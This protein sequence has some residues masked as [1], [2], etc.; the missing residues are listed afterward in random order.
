MVKRKK[1]SRRVTAR[2]KTTRKA[3]NVGSLVQLELKDRVKAE[4]WAVIYLSL[5]LL[6]FLSITGRLGIVGEFVIN[7]LNPIFG[8][9]IY[10]LPAVLFGIAF[11]LFFIE[12]VRLN[13]TK[14]FGIALLFASVLGF[15]HLAVPMEE[16][17][18]YAKS[19]T[20]GGYIGFVVSFLLQSVLGKTGAYIVLVS[21]FIIAFLV[22]F[23]VSIS[24]VW[25]ALR[26]ELP[27]KIEK[28]PKAPRKKTGIM[29]QDTEGEMDINIIAPDSLDELK[30][31][32]EAEALMKQ[33]MNEDTNIIFESDGDELIKEYEKTLDINE[34][35]NKKFATSSDII[36]DEEKPY[37]PIEWE[38]P[39]VDLLEENTE[40][41]V[42]DN[43]VIKRNA[44]NI[45]NKL[46][47]FNIDV[48]MKDVHVGPTVVQYSLKPHEGVKLSKIT[49]LKQDL[50]LALAAKAI[51][52]EAPIPGQSLVG[53]EVPNETRSTV[54][55]RDLIESKEY[56]KTTSKLK[57]AI[58]RDVCGRSVIADLAK[59][60]HLLIAG[61]TGSGKS[62]GMNSFL[63]SLLYNN[64]PEELKMI[65][66]D[67]KRV[68][69]NNYN[70]IPHLLTPVITDPE[71]AATSLRWAVAEMNSRYQTLA[72]AG[73]RHIGDYNADDN[74]IVKMPKIII[75]ID[76]L[77]DLMMASG[78]EVEASICRIAQMA[79][80]IG[81]H[82]IIATQRPS[83][84]VITGLI[85]ANIPARIA[86]TVS[87]QI[88]SRTI[89]DGVGAEDLLGQGD[90]LYLPGNMGK[91][92]RVQGI[93][94][95]SKEIERV[96]NRVKLTMQP[97][98]LEEIT[99]RDTA[100]MKVNGVPGGMDGTDDELYQEAIDIVR[101]TKKASASFLQRR[102]SIGYNR[103]AR[104]IELMEEQGLVGPQETSKSREVHM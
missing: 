80:A 86:F 28:L 95:S 83:V 101:Q 61:A 60:P 17:F 36:I 21:A 35:G 45:Q 53:I 48:T 92:F 3:S 89:I 40:G 10:A 5:S 11:S 63:I 15:V 58:G 23:E 52:I 39:S 70:S 98:Y 14:I 96:T 75:V 67:P 19:G 44:E 42:I 94:I 9:G 46:S 49:A 66:I 62:V 65:L 84:D 88:D 26:P 43:E 6:T 54:Y 79:R 72:D 22:I 34:D 90:M 47:T 71:K 57:L 27:M 20:Y 97:D 68:E 56:Q 50:A 12:R 41:I 25:N 69:L 18:E 55:M 78:K 16:I 33:A 77:A 74:I 81:M 13:A 102:L 99:S 82:L 64:S 31:T 100:Q 104:L 30:V 87:S 59:M 91:P 37:E 8:W 85:K 4:I 51:R 93:Y 2:R 1:I 32:Q 76:E 103:A 73:H 7:F 29:T 24:D 38:Y